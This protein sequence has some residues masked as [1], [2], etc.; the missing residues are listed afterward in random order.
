MGPLAGLTVLDATWGSPGSIATM[1]LAD[2]G[3][4]VIKIERP[5]GDEPQIDLLR[6]AWQRGK[7]SIELDLTNAADLD[8]LIALMAQADIFLESFG[9]GKAET[10]GLGYDDLKDR[11]PRLI[12]GSITGFGHDTP[13]RDEPGY[14]AI[15]TAKLG[16]MA[17]QASVE[18]DGPIFLGHPNTA[19]GTGFITAI[20]LL[21]AVRARHQTGRGQRVDTSMLDGVL[22]QSPM[23][24]W[25]HPEGVSYVEVQNGK[26][27]GY[28]YKRLITGAFLCEDGEYIQVHTGGQGGFKSVMEVFGFGDICQDTGGKADMSVPLNDEEYAIARDYIP[29]AF[30]QRPR[31]E[32]LAEFK[33]LDVAC[34]PVLRQGEV[35]ADAQIEFAKM[36]IEVQH[37]TLGTLKQAAPPVR[38][39]KAPIETPRP[40]P[41]RGQDNEAIRAR[42][43]QLAPA[44]P[45]ATGKP[46]RHAL[47]GIRVVDLSSFFATGYG[48]KMLSDLGADVIL[49]EPPRGEQMRPLPNPFEAAQRGKRNIVVDLKTAEGQALVHDLIRTA[50]VVMHNQRPG[51]AEKVGIGYDQLSAINPN[52]VYCY[53]P[54]FGSA[55]PRAF[56]KSFAPLQSGFTGLLFEG[57]GEGNRPVRT[58]EGNEDYYNGLLGATAAL[59]GLAHRDRTGEGQYIECPQLH[60][61][62]FVSSHQFLGEG[63]KSLT[64]LLLDHDQTGWG[65][66]YRLYQT[67]DDWIVIAAVGNRA[68][69]RA[70]E[71]LKLDAALVA[72]CATEAGRKANAEALQ[73]AVANALSGMTSQA[74][75][76]LLRGAR[77]ACEIPAKLPVVPTLFHEQW[78]LD[79]GRVFEQPE[80]MHGPIREIGH[81]FRLSDTP[82]QKKG[83]APRLGQYTRPILAELGYDA[84]KIDALIAKKVVIAE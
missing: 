45:A 40:A 42:A 55:G 2:N 68:F 82:A 20:S 18:R 57:G 56:D 26:R 54:G 39:R 66:L 74:A 41:L 49:V 72:D 36:A 14:D 46:I 6:L 76:A 21:A 65:P 60:S 5:E 12:Y 50:D 10:L 81:Y 31:A 43:T 47:E 17:E 44:A 73:D 28:G 3:A 52:L 84:A 69:A 15:V 32:W 80:T 78:A 8:V 61:S 83:P 33:A 22:A 11:F 30:Q 27:V 48:A 16:M 29:E 64:A 23:N 24:H 9:P 59:S 51:K 25:Y 34:I 67:S 53:L 37:P 77:V 7:K 1:L 62:M 71:A 79:S 19:Y 38:F 70:A 13:W 75:Y 63:K 35:L 58:I 4:D